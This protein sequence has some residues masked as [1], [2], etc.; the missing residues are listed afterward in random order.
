MSLDSFVVG[1]WSFILAKI[2]INFHKTPYVTF[3]LAEIIVPKHEI[4]FFLY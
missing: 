4:M 3:D 1:W 2:L